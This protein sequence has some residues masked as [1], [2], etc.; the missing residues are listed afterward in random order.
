MVMGLP[1]PIWDHRVVIG[2]GQKIIQRA[3]FIGASPPR[4]H[5][6]GP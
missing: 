1:I 2:Q 5:L 4:K 3:G 6:R